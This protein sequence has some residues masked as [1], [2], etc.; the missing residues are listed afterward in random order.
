MQPPIRHI[1]C[2]PVLCKE[3]IHQRHRFRPSIIGSNVHDLNAQAFVNR[4]NS[5][6]EQSIPFFFVAAATTQ[7]QS[8]FLTKSGSLRTEIQLK[9][10][11]SL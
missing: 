6:M 11:L 2:I 4:Q 9:V 8:S 1:I 10:D 3:R 7:S 5:A